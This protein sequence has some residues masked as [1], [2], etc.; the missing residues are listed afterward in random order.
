MTSILLTELSPQALIH[1]FDKYLRSNGLY[2]NYWVF[3]SV[4]RF[5]GK[6]CIRDKLMQWRGKER[7]SAFQVS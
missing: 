3:H 7:L 4:S 1:P 6:T 2:S 5:V